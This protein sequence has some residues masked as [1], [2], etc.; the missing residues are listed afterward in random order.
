MPPPAELWNRPQDG[1]LWIQK[2]TAVELG[3]LALYLIVWGYV[4][5]YRRKEYVGGVTGGPQGWRA[6]LGG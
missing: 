6:H 4:G 1:I 3:V 5:I 2:V